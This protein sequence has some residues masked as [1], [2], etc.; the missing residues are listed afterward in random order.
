MVLVI[1]FGVTN[2]F[3]QKISQED[4][5]LLEEQ[6]LEIAKMMPN[7]SQ[8]YKLA[9]ERTFDSVSKASDVIIFESFDSGPTIVRFTAETKE[10]E[11]FENCICTV[12]L[13]EDNDGLLFEDCESSEV[14]FDKTVFI[15]EGELKEA[16]ELDMAL[17]GQ[18][19]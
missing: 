17:F 16:Y 7:T 6:M 9:I 1:G 14:V 10:G 18:A 5:D 2:V 4:M 11:V 13:S 8:L 3:A 12:V 19:E 15:S